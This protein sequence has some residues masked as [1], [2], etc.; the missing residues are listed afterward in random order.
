M[1]QPYQLGGNIVFRNTRPDLIMAFDKANGVMYEL[2]DTATSVLKLIDGRRD[3]DSIVAELME[4]F[5]AEE[6]D[7]RAD[8]ES[9]IRRFIEVALIVPA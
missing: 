9:I 7:L 6:P 2:N 1:N 5:E 8:V 3:L 4:E